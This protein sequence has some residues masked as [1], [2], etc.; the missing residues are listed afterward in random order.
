[1][2][3][4]NARGVTLPET[5]ADAS[6]VNVGRWERAGSVGLGVFLATLGM[7]RGGWAAAVGAISGGAL[8]YRGLSGHCHVYGALGRNTAT[9]KELGMARMEKGASAS[10]A[11]DRGIKL[12]Q[13]ILVRRRPEDVYAFFR[14][15]HNLPRVMSHVE[16]VEV[17]SSALSHWKVRGPAGSHVEWDA[18]IIND[19]PGELL[20]WRSREGADV[21]NA[22]SVHFTPREGGLA[23][24]VRVQLKYDPPAG[25]LGAAIARLFGESPEVQMKDDLARLK[26]ELE[27]SPRAGEVRP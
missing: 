22:G 9:R 7:K 14:D 16:A 11:I 15:L 20:A 17:S 21:P 24:E 23:T 26:R 10:I 12:D 25:P 19:R 5:Y 3:A 6:N 1:M 27:V 4:D 13:R 2:N 8:V 18:E